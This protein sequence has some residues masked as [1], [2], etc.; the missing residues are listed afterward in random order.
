[1]D[2]LGYVL[3]AMGGFMVGGVLNIAYLLF[4]AITH[5]T[6]FSFERR[7]PRIV[8]MIAF[9]AGLCLLVIQTIVVGSI[10][11]KKLTMD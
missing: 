4:V 11:W 3:I 2:G 6:H 9:I 8:A 5:R 10:A 1:M 7:R